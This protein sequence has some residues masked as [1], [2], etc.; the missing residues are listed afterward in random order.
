MMSLA[1]SGGVGRKRK[2][3]RVI[4]TGHCG[5][6][7]RT[8]GGG[9]ECL[10][11][12][13]NKLGKV[14]HTIGSKPRHVGGSSSILGGRMIRGEESRPSTNG[15]FGMTGR[16]TSVGAPF[17]DGPSIDINGA[18]QFPNGNTASRSISVWCMIEN[19]K[20]IHGRSTGRG[21]T[22][23]QH[24]TSGKNGLQLWDTVEF[25]R[26]GWNPMI[27]HPRTTTTAITEFWSP[28]LCSR[29]GAVILQTVRLVGT[30][31]RSRRRR[32]RRRRRSHNSGMEPQEKRGQHPKGHDTQDKPKFP[33]PPRASLSTGTGRPGLLHCSFFFSSDP[34][35]RIFFSFFFF[36][37]DSN[38]IDRHC[39]GRMQEWLSQPHSQPRSLSLSFSMRF[40]Y[41][42]QYES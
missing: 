2:R 17:R 18:F 40:C 4:G 8:R 24:A 13:T 19:G 20:H 11:F 32:R 25:V 37:F 6:R 33:N 21:I 28:R 42:R 1:S 27:A 7:C 26:S 5:R 35:V 31:R 14:L 22:N 23:P 29:G 16:P 9:V 10:E 3:R 34:L 41:L 38:R 30:N 39:A 12:G 15:N 36:F